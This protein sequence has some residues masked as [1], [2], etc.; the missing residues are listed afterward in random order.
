[1]QQGRNSLV[2]SP[3]DLKFGEMIGLASV[4]ILYFMEKVSLVIKIPEF[5]PIFLTGL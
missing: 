3:N 1:M 5:L 4:L 2:S